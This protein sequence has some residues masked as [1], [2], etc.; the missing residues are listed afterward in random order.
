MDGN[1]SINESL[2]LKALLMTF[3]NHSI[4]IVLAAALIA[5]VTAVYSIY[6][7]DPMYSSTSQ[8][9]VE[10]DKNSYQHHCRRNDDRSKACRNVSHYFKK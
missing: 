8:L 1:S 5:S 10:T 6:F 4:L 7:V 3:L 9:Y 2:D